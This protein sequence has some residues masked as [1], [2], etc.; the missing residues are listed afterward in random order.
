M[1]IKHDMV[2]FQREIAQLKHYYGDVR[3]KFSFFFKYLRDQIF[4]LRFSKFNNSL[5]ESEMKNQMLGLN[6]MYLLSQNKLPEFHMVN[7]QKFHHLRYKNSNFKFN[8]FL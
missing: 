4:L 8:T 2:G 3:W 6:L 7:E 1:C 5:K